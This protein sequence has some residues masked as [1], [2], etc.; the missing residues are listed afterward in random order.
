[1]SPRAQ[2]RA[3]FPP[4]HRLLCHMRCAFA[5]PLSA[6]H[7]CSAAVRAAAVCIAAAHTRA[8]RKRLRAPT[9]TCIVVCTAAF[10]L[11]ASRP[12]LRARSAPY[13]THPVLR[14]RAPRRNLRECAP[15]HCARALCTRSGWNL[16]RMR[17]PQPARA[18]RRTVRVRGIEKRR[19]ATFSQRA[20]LLPK[21]DMHAALFMAMRRLRLHTVLTSTT[22]KKRKWNTLA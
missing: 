6:R 10:Y 1:M 20:T 9:P 12:N 14:A 11:H 3:R 13:S 2:P 4:R 8:L 15:P 18:R 19:R 21:K 16:T 7:A 17:A 5:T 22:L